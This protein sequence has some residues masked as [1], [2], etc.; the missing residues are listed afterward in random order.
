MTTDRGSC[1]PRERRGRP[2]IRI[3]GYTWS[4]SLRTAG[5][6]RRLQARRSGSNWTGF[7]PPHL[8]RRRM[9]PRLM[10]SWQCTRA[11]MLDFRPTRV[12]KRELLAMTP[13]TSQFAQRLRAIA[14][15][16]DAEQARFDYAAASRPRGAERY[17]AGA[18]RSPAP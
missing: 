15:N 1:P 3:G 8:L 9:R 11:P 5:Q 14:V 10:L 12:L 2:S 7:R 17:D 13:G 4:T 16:L 18:S 6:P